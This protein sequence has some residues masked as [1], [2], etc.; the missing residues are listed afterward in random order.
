[1]GSE[2]G[3]EKEAGAR[4]PGRTEN[5]STTPTAER[6]APQDYTSLA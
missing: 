6:A 2:P 3:E 4:G 1:M 5:P